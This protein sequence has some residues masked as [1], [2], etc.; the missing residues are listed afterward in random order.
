MTDPF[1][2]FT[3]QLLGHLLTGSEKAPFYKALIESNI[4]SGFAP[5]HGYVQ[6]HCPSPC[7]MNYNVFV[8]IVFCE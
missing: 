7:V 1:E 2:N 3:L 8:Q 6:V 5:E 4:G